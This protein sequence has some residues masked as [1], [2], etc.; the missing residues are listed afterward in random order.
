M[1]QGAHYLHTY[2][3]KVMNARKSTQEMAGSFLFAV[4]CLL[5]VGL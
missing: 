4:C 5:P 2:G 3:N 1:F